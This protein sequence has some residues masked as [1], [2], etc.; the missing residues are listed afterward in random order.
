MNKMRKK[1]VSAVA[2]VI[3]TGAVLG[4]AEFGFGTAERKRAAE[5]EQQLRDHRE[6][7]VK[8]TAYKTRWGKTKYRHTEVTVN[9]FGEE[10]NEE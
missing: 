5:R 10:V 7:V 4:G 6:K 1:I 3:G 8:T 9:G 2:L